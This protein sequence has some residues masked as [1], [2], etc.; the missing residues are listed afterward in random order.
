MGCEEGRIEE[1]EEGGAGNG[2]LVVESG[3]GGGD[4]GGAESVRS[5]RRVGEGIGGEVDERLV[6]EIRDLG[7]PSLHLTPHSL[8]RSLSPFC[9]LPRNRRLHPLRF[10]HFRSLCLLRQD[11]RRLSLLLDRQVLLISFFLFLFQF[12]S[13]FHFNLLCL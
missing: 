8:H 10:P 11:P 13:L 2:A 5:G 12:H 1:E 7:N 4:S 6:R 9:Y 3:G